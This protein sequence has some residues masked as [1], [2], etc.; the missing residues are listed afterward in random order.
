MATRVA[1][2][3]LLDTNVLLAATDRRR[4]EHTRALASL[5]EW[6]GIGTVLYSSSQIFREYLSVST[7]PIENN[8]LGLSQQDALVNVRAFRGRLRV[9]E[10]NSRVFEALLSLLDATPCSGKQVHDANLVATALAHGIEAIVT[11]NVD[12]FARFDE[13]VRVID[14]LAT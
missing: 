11:V 4:R 6:P 10:E 8:G 14:L 1:D 3:V 5:D 2:R 9:L 7:R 13:H 12:D